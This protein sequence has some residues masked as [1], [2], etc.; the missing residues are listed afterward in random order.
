MTRREFGLE[1]L[2]PQIRNKGSNPKF[3]SR[4]CHPERREGS[5]IIFPGSPPMR[6]GDVSLDERG[7]RE[8]GNF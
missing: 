5:P 8:L 7:E 4:D 3:Q 1:D 6:N 2:E